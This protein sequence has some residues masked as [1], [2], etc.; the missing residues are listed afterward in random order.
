MNS[1]PRN[2]RHVERLADLA[3]AA[4]LVIG[5]ALVIAPNTAAALLV[6]PAGRRRA[7][8]IGCL[9]LS[10]AA[11]LLLPHQRR[12]WM[13][14]RAAL[15]AALAIHYRRP[16]TGRSQATRHRASQALT[17]LT[18]IDASVALLLPPAIPMS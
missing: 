5:L 14:A 12:S 2:D 10:L 6:L 9:D 16:A 18:V 15:N 13:L 1:S 11:G 8:L 4:S 3:G 7:Q 17:T